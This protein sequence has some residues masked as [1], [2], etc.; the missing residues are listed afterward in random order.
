MTIAAHISAPGGL[1][2]INNYNYVHLNILAERYPEHHFV[3]IFDKPFDPSIVHHSNITP[4]NLGPQMR[5]NLLKHYWHNFKL[6]RILN[7]YNADIFIADGNV[8][9]LN[10]SVKQCMVIHD[11]SFLHRESLYNKGQSRYLKKY[12]KNFLVKASIVVVENERLRDEL[13]TITLVNKIHIVS[14]DFAMHKFEYAE[15]IPAIK[16]HY[17]KGREYFIFYVTDASVKHIVIVLKAFSLFKKRQLSNMQLL[18][19]I[20]STQKNNIAKDLS[21]YKYRSEVLQLFI[22]NAAMENELTAAAYAALY[23]PAF[24]LLEDKSRLAIVN[25]I[26]VICT[27][28]LYL[29]S[30]FKELAL[31]SEIDETAIAEKM[32]LIY[33]D[34]NLRNALVR[35][36]VVAQSQEQASTADKLW[37][38]F[39]GSAAENHLTLP[40]K[41]E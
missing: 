37:A 15:K 32:M 21:T 33:K 20:T 24:E 35:N 28:N 27:D 39:T 13:S 16:D 26:P 41:N 23:F 30:T 17:T 7:R 22:K 3:F 14:N 9:S 11:L 4:V 12:L 34:E 1:S 8:C 29:H 18:L 10:S 6:P 5:N 25:N 2:S 36:S 19:S 38:V 31:Y 40:L